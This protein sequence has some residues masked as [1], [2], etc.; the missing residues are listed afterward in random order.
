M[1]NTRSEPTVSVIIPT[2]N[3]AEFVGRAIKS[4]LNQTYR[5]F[6]LLVVDDG[7]SDNTKE[8]VKDFKSSRLKYIRHEEN[9]G[10]SS[11]RNSGIKKSTGKY[12]A[13]LD[14]DDEW[15]PGK[16]EKQVER[17]SASE[18]SDVGLVYTGAYILKKPGQI[19][20]KQTPS[21]S[22]QLFNTILKKGNIVCGG[23]SSVLIKRECF[24]EVGVFR[25]D[26]PAAEDYEMWLRIARFFKFDYIEELSVKYYE[27]ANNRM[28]NNPVAHEEACWY[29]YENY[30]S[31]HLHPLMR[32]K[33][34]ANRLSIVGHLYCKNASMMEG[35][36]KLLYS[37]RLNPFSYR[38]W[39]RILLSLLGE[40]R[41]EAGYKALV[42]MR[43]R[44]L[45]YV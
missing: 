1:P 37:L 4:V 42:S 13:F 14:S 44:V 30:Y 26:L 39:L 40:S 9:E 11:A 23:G 8:V 12:L 27:Q 41:Y 18:F 21:H 28:S 19:I 45:D 25:E 31:K 33:R 10:V 15:L 5:N 6:E 16:L 24:N 20:S 17:F 2:Y 43:R 35:R 3:R 34:L 32:R 38:S 36:K 29:L 22:G 7:S